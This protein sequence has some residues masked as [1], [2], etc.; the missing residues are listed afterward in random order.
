MDLA[1]DMRHAESAVA[2]PDVY[3]LDSACEVESE[4]LGSASGHLGSNQQ[5]SDFAGVLLPQ[6]VVCGK[7]VFPSHQRIGKDTSFKLFLVLTTYFYN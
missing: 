1:H 2:Q 7:K 6:F 5:A 3:A 4:Q